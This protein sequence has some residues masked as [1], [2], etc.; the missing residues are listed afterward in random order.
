MKL[1][2]PVP[3]LPVSD[4]REAGKAY[5]EQMGFTVDWM[6]EDFLAGISKD[7]ARIF[8]RQRTAEEA[9]QRYTATVW[10]NMDSAEDV[11]RLHAAWKDRGVSIVKELQTAPYNLREFT[12][13]DLDGNKFRVFHDLSGDTGS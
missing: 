3:E 9:E 11:D 2:S 1:P 6:Y 13:A 7:D 5:E 12:A 10:L 8:L 4:I